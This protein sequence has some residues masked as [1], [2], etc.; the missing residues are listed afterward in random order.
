MTPCS[1]DYAYFLVLEE[2]FLRRSNLNIR[3]ANIIHNK[4]SIRK[5]KMLFNIFIGENTF[6]INV[7]NRPTAI[8]KKNVSFFDIR[9]PLL[10]NGLRGRLTE[11]AEA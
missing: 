5:N 7:A 6:L 10:T 3:G 8:P 11:P 4:N 1:S 2:F 9:R